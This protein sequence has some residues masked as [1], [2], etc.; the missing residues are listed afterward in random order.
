MSDGVDGGGGEAAKPTAEERKAQVAILV[1]A[2][3]RFQ[4]SKNKPIAGIRA[5]ME[6][7][8]VR[9]VSRA[10]GRSVAAS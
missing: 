1:V 7:K 6:V 10:I 9:F 3:E 2:S 4:Q 5:K 8:E